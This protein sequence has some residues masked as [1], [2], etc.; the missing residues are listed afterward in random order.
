MVPHEALEEAVRKAGG[1]TALARALGGTI[2][3]G[4]VWRWLNIAGQP[5]AEYTLPIE[6]IS[7]VSRHD[8]RP[9]LYP[10]V[11]GAAA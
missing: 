6:K 3:Q 2:K 10:T 8:L 5:P 9:D 4:H 1:Q 11:S 7:G